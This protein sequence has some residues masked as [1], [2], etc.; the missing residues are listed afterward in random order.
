[1]RI[2]IHQP[3]F[4]PVKGYFDK[5]A[6]VDLF[7]IMINCQWEKGKYQNRFHVEKQW[8]TMSVNHGLEPIKDKTYTKPYED[9]ERITRRFKNM[10]VFDHC[11]SDKLH[12]MNF[13]IIR[14]AALMQGINTEIRL[15]F[16]T[17]LLGTQRLVEICQYYEADE[18][19]SG[20]SGKKYL[21]VKQ[22][23]NAGIRVDFQEKT[24]LTPLIELI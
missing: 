7:V 12:A 22:F 4:C 11:V 6:A 13:C 18:Y 9:W 14:E 20:P 2:A 19:L 21:D 24:D 10:K 16:P 23:D 1:M 5:I 8:N 15:D 17:H 3:N